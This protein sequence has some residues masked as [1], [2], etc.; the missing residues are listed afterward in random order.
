MTVRTLTD[1][2][3]IEQLLVELTL[4]LDARALSA[5]V[6]RRGLVEQ[7][8]VAARARCADDRRRLGDTR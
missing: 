8:Q 7:A 1:E 4:G 2:Q 3:L 5:E 6:Q